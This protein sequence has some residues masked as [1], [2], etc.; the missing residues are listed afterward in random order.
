MA[1]LMGAYSNGL[2]NSGDWWQSAVAQSTLEAYQQATGDTSYYSDIVTTYDDWNAKSQPDSKPD[3]EDGYADDTAWWG[4]AWIQA[5]TM[6]G[7]S[8]YLNTAEADANYIY[9]DFWDSNATGCDGT[10]GG[11][12]WYDDG[13]TPTGRLTIPNVLFLEL[14]ADLHNAIGGDTKYLGYATSEYNWLNDSGLIGSNGLVWDGFNGS[15]ALSGTYWTYNQGSAIAA[16][17]EYYKATGTAGLIT[18]AEKIGTAAIA[19]L[20]PTGVLAETCEPSGCDGDQVAFKGIFVRDLEILAA[21][22]GTGQFDSF[23]Q[24]QAAAIEAHDTTSANKFG[25]V[26]SGPTPT[27]PSALT[28]ANP[29]DQASQ[30]SAEDALVAALNPPVERPSAVVGAD[31]TVRVFARTATGSLEVDSLPAGSSTWSGFTSLG[32]NSPTSPSAL[33]AANGATWAF[34]TG[35][36]G[37]LYADTLAY[38]ATAWAGWVSLGK[39]S[40]NLLGVPAVVED[41]GGVIRAFVRSADG[42]LWTDS[43]SG[44]AWSGFSS[45]G[46]VWP[47]DVAAVAGSGGYVHLYATGTT[48]AMYHDQALGSG[49]WSG[50]ANLGGTV[51]GVPAAIQDT[52]NTLRA[53]APDVSSGVLEEFHAAG[54]STTYGEDSRG[55][56]WPYDA[57]AAAGSGGYVD[58]FDV[59]LTDNAYWQYLTPAPAWSS[60]VNLGGS[61]TGTPTAVKLGDGNIVL[62]AAS[63]SGSLE[64]DQLTSGTTTWSGWVTLGG[65]L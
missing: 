43:Y 49:S 50:W 17:T 10:G 33:A 45:L 36:N 37:V 4:L 59:G 32:G 57:A 53:Y 6:T 38:G 58:V 21:V 55:G 15:C 47:Y 63:T 52:G 5:Y 54:G 46:G 60:W 20:A 27:C 29:C 44:S 40:V 25:L 31:G 62:F 9:S 39:P 34:V 7:D 1:T 64:V 42:D 13:G 14:T 8:A 56:S 26:W 61:F 11:V 2:I 35:A 30:A 51:A 41:T 28:T 3:F 65:S 48:T 19:D 16:L 18:E 22:A 23:F 12:W 24:A